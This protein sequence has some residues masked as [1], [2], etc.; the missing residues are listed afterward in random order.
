[1][2][3]AW[4]GESLNNR[5]ADKRGC[6]VLHFAITDLLCLPLGLSSAAR[7]L[8]NYPKSQLM[9]Q[10]STQFLGIHVEPNTMRLSLPQAKVKH[11]P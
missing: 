10:Q 9:P 11:I 5:G 6:T 3:I 1:M 8:I 7:V 4:A 2:Y